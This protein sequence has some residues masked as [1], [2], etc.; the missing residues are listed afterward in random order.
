MNKYLFLVVL[1]ALGLVIAAC[2][3]EVE[4]VREVEVTREVQVATEAQ[5]VVTPADPLDVVQG[6][7]AALNAG[8]L[9][10]IVGL[11]SDDIVFTIGPFP[12]EDT[13]DTLT[14]KAENL[15]DDADTIKKHGRLSFT[16]TSVA[17]D[18]VKGKFSYADDELKGFG[19]DTI[20]G[21][22]ES[23]V[24]QGQITS[25]KGLI[26]EKTQQM[27]AAAFAPPA[28]RELT[29]L[30]GAG[31]DTLSVNAFLPS[32]V[33]VRVGDTVTWKLN[34][35]DEV[36]TTTFLSGGERPPV[37]IPIPGGGPTDL[38][39]PPPVVFP[40]RAPGAPVETYSGTA[41]VGSG[42]MSNVPAGP[43]GT[44]PNDNFTLTFDTPGTYEYVCLLH[45]PMK[46]TITVVDATVADVSSQAEIDA[47]A[48]AEEAPLRA[49]I[50]RIVEAGQKV[51]SEPG[52]NG[53][54]IYYV[55]AGAGGWPA[56]AQTFDFLAK[57]ITIQEGDTV[58]WTSEMFHNVTFHPGRMH[59]IFIIPKPQD[60]GPPIISL[61]P[62]VVFPHK[63]AGVFDGTGFWS[64]GIIGIDTMPLPGGKTFSM[65]FGK[66]GTFKYMCA[67][68]RTLGMTGSVTVTPKERAAGPTNTVAFQ[69]FGW[70][71]DT[72]GASGSVTY[73][74]VAGSFS[75]EVEVAGLKASH[76]YNLY[77]MNVGVIGD[78]TLDTTTYGFT[79]DSQGAAK[80]SVSKT[81]DVAEKAPL[82]AYQVHF[83]VVDGAADLA[84]PPNPFGIKHPIA[85][86]CSFP[87]GFLQLDV[88]GLPATA[89]SGDKVPLFN[90]GWAPGYSGG[91]GSVSYTGQNAPFEATL[92][93]AGLK[94]SH[95]YSVVM[96]DS[97][98][99]GAIV[100]KEFVINTNPNGAASIAISHE[101]AV[102][103][104][105][106]LPAF[107]VHFLVID[108]SETV[109]NPTNPF[110]IKNPIPLACMFPLGFLQLGLGPK[111]IQAPLPVPATAKGPAVPQ[112]KGYLVEE[113][114]DGLYWVTNGTYQVMF[115]TTGEG[116]IVVDAPASIGENVLKAI[117]EVTDEPVTHFIYSH[118]HKDHVGAS[119]IFSDT[120]TYIGHE[121]TAARLALTNDPNR[122][123]PT[124]T[125]ADSYTLKVGTQTLELENRGA[126]HTQGNIYI[127]AP[128][129]KV[130][131]KVDMISP[132]WAS[133]KD[134]SV[135]ED[136]GG[137]I[138]AHDE[139]LSYDFDTFM[140]GHLTRLGNR[141]D[142]EIAKEYIGSL[143]ANAGKALGAVDFMTIGQQTGFE[144]L[145][146][147]FD[148]FFD[149][150][151]Q[152][153]ADETIAQ[154][155]DKLGGVNIWAFDHC[156]TLALYLA[157]TS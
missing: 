24:V 1:F 151:A 134:L 97:P 129:Q 67:I 77:F 33:T 115:L 111:T 125:F 112:D 80:I 95:K 124:V 5:L 91:T 156:W 42:V 47:M 12:P 25:M 37:A 62:E 145:Y 122:P 153:C 34:H 35:S 155:G 84:E 93:V 13:F 14:G 114:K 73:H 87:L 6:Y 48:A 66:A 9:D 119:G 102:P 28:P 152:Q 43:P 110:G 113:I 142:V 29:L 8:D 126:D 52:P 54:T 149:T 148:T 68:H 55:Q 32:K 103:E 127:Y 109:E 58:V 63:P 101:F 136:I 27:F 90:F 7:G 36:H 38:Q 138:R 96:M 40:T 94:P 2:T 92:N 50:E 157:N 116:V 64:S 131:M 16:N 139:V 98:L 105:V 18:T 137:F 26:D 133:F 120:A 150:V 19:V 118:F 146:L 69:D 46:A 72:K 60:Q 89:L 83:L 76:A 45:P 3:T 100:S 141:Q 108:R 17:G 23:V 49:Q 11:Y 59:P 51:R 99:N 22:F 135:A 144:N 61:N 39:L 81:F 57:D 30:V 75:G 20:T 107:Q 70:D 88:P 140:G 130:L 147:L 154:W 143:Q 86:A 121:A 104:G 31:E 10:T 79:T 82:P 106:P 132:G 44:P 123:V 85:L 65:T 78:S 15:A 74:P 41:F 53:T 117:A 4:V 21:T 56:T 71:P 128:K